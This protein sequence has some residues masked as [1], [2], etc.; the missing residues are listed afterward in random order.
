MKL[1]I[2]VAA[3]IGLPLF[4]GLAALGLWQLYVLEMAPVFLAM[5]LVDQLARPEWLL[6]VCLL[7]AGQLESRGPLAVLGHG[8][9]VTLRGGSRPSGS[10]RPA[11]ESRVGLLLAPSAGLIL[12]GAAL[13][14]LMNAGSRLAIDLHRAA[15]IPL[16]AVLLVSLW[17]RPGLFGGLL[18]SPL[19]WISALAMAGFYV[20][21]L[22]LIWLVMIMLLLAHAAGWRDTFGTPSSNPHQ[23][24]YFDLLSHAAAQSG[25][26]VLLFGLS[27][28]LVQLLAGE[29][30]ASPNGLLSGGWLPV[31][32]FLAA[33]L[34]LLG[35]ILPPLVWLAVL[36]PWLP[37]A[38]DHLA[39]APISLGVL[40][41]FI[42]SMVGYY[43][44]RAVATHSD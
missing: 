19:A 32:V 8:W 24:N 11:M 17:F 28:V 37:V 21:V 25:A 22:P 42:L 40:L 15:L 3:A 38:A 29:L 34:I 16:V 43:P 6:L 13:G 5:M 9:R 20:G 10:D 2:I 35:R 7:V 14:D 12:V 1:L 4:A 39:L 27:M 41:V 36:A 26:L 23:R 31:A 44:A 18:K 30:M 33:M